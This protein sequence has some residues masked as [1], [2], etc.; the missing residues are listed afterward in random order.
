MRLTTVLFNYSC[1]YFVTVSGVNSSE[2]WVNITDDD[3]ISGR[4]FTILNAG[5]NFY[6]VIDGSN[7]EESMTCNYMRI[8]CV[9]LV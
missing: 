2:E 5:T 8:I 6:Y 4:Y 3:L 7:T 9:K 1:L